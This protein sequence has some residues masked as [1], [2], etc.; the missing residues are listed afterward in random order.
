MIEREAQQ[1]AE[2]N[3]HA[4]RR[5]LG[6]HRSTIVNRNR[7]QEWQVHFNKAHLVLLRMGGNWRSAAAI[8][9]KQSFAGAQ[10]CNLVHL[11][12]KSPPFTAKALP[13]TAKS[14]PFSQPDC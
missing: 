11:A 5:F 14:P 4:P 7:V 1:F 6:I 3:Q 8:M 13:F 2:P 10:R 12:P 9:T